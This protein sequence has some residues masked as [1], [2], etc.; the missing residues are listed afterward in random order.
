MSDIREEEMVQ[1]KGSEKA[2]VG[3]DDVSTF[4]KNR[5][6]ERFLSSLEMENDV[7]SE[8]NHSTNERKLKEKT[9]TEKANKKQQKLHKWESKEFIVY[10]PETQIEQRYETKV[11]IEQQDKAAVETLAKKNEEELDK[12]EES[13]DVKDEVNKNDNVSD[14]DV[15]EKE[16]KESSEENRNEIK[17]VEKIVKDNQKKVLREQKSFSE[18]VSISPT[19]FLL[20]LLPKREIV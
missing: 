2:N 10:R 8:M 15:T 4:E 18:Q 12:S 7:T 6:Q 14:F 3:S 16:K 17:E 19:Y 20:N 13:I 9:E 1:L 11:L 5:D